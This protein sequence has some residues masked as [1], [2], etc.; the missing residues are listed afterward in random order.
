MSIDATVTGIAFLHDGK[1]RLT[2]EQPDRSR[3]AGQSSLTVDEPPANLE[4]L[5][6]RAIWGGD[7]TIMCGEIEVGRREG[8]TGLRVS[9]V[10]LERVKATGSGGADRRLAR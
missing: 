4:I 1:A 8:Y 7:T 3:C 2:L 5:L 6:G 9:A 10:A